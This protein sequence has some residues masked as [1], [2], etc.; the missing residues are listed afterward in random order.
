MNN[1]YSNISAVKGLEFKW[2]ILATYPYRL[3]FHAMIFCL[4]ST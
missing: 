1:N 3:T 2:T 4:T